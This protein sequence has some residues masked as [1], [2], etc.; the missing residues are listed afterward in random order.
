MNNER[1][2]AIN[3]V[4]G[5][6]R[7]NLIDVEAELRRIEG[8][9]MDCNYVLGFN[10]IEENPNLG[11]FIRPGVGADR[12]AVGGIVGAMRMNLEE[13][14]RLAPVLRNGN[15]ENPVPVRYRPALVAYR[16]ELL[17]MIGELLNMLGE[18]EV[19]N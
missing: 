6:Y 17:R 3:E 14:E 8:V 11:L 2:A 9:L 12:I 18:L 16:N 4:L 5:V 10:L 1:I 15:D 13:A 7:D 19:V